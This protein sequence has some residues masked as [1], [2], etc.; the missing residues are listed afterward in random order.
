MKPNWFSTAAVDSVWRS[1]P[2]TCKRWDTQTSFRWMAAPAIGAT[3]AIRWRSEFIW[4]RSM[5]G[6]KSKRILHHVQ[7]NHVEHQRPD[8]GHSGKGRRDAD[9]LRRRPA[10]EFLVKEK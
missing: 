7:H 6:A 10:A 1:L 8:Q 2:T 9:A 5:I 3:A 4:R